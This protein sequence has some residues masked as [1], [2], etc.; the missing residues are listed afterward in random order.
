MR[1]CVVVWPAVAAA[2]F[3]LES[4]QATADDAAGAQ[5]QTNVPTA[6]V[7]SADSTAP[8]DNAPLTVMDVRGPDGLIYPNWTWAGVQGGIP[9]P[10]AI[11]VNLADK[12]AKPET[13]ISALL[14]KTADELGAKGGGAI[15]LG[16]GTYYLDNP[17]FIRCS[18]IVL[19]GAGKDKTKLIFR[20]S[21]AKGE[22]KFYGVES[23]GSFE[24]LYIAAAPD[25]G[26][27]ASMAGTKDLFRWSKA[28]GAAWVSP[29][30]KLTILGDGKVLTSVTHIPPNSAV[31]QANDD[32]GN[33][34]YCAIDR[35]KVLRELGPGVHQFEGLVEYG[36]GTTAKGDISL[37]VSPTP[38]SNTIYGGDLAAISFEGGPPSDSHILLAADGVRGTRQ[39]L[40]QKGGHLQK[41]DYIQLIAPPSPRW[42]K[43]TG[44]VD[45][46][47]WALF[48]SNQYQ[49]TDVNGDAVKLNQPLRLDFP[50][51]DGSYAQ[52][53]HPVTG[54]GIENLSLEQ[55]ANLWISGVHFA[56][57]WNCWARNVTIINAGR[58]PIYFLDSKFGEV[59]DCVFNGAQFTGGGGSAYAG[60]ERSYDCLMENVETFGLRHGPILNWACSGDVIR[61]S[62][63]HEINGGHWHAGWCNN[64]L[65]EN[66][67]IDSTL[68]AG[69][70]AFGPKYFKVH[71]PQGPNNVVYNCDVQVT[72]GAGNDVG[73]WLMGRDEHWLFVYNRFQ[74]KFGAGT[75]MEDYC[76]DITIRDNV[77]CF[78]H[79][80]PDAFE[81]H[82]ATCSG[83]KFI[84]N[85]I[86]GQITA[87]VASTAQGYTA[88][89]NVIAPYQVAPRP[90][91]PVP[92]IFEWER[93][94]HLTA[95]R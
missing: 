91:P 46:S 30:R 61:N 66:C 26:D 18:N 33:R 12:G 14:E 75:L 95:G 39:L 31:V 43:L 44:N 85:H 22:V 25:E 80:Y 15:V 67:I 17:V 59:R 19:R 68:R 79:S 27:P 23:G 50:R 10:P 65:Y 28:G 72:R 86:Y 11:Q 9:S 78:A 42:N 87:L 55:T 83:I 5:P 45:V 82:D 89:G 1:L 48:R 29:I 81:F 16:A 24:N 3:A 94:Q 34:F 2:L 60:F 84:D 37:Q 74:V 77:F 58:H 71:G 4:R 38:V 49:I 62:V 51:V 47:H 64:N 56:E 90:T 93:Q 36:D 70:M 13:D 92:S 52:V 20:Y 73:I 6:T 32:W 88:E 8:N 41:G 69:L 40:L 53:F 76:R 63:F 54:C 57:S 21:I 35:E 7:P